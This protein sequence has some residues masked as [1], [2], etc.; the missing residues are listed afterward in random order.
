MRRRSLLVIGFFV[1]TL[2][3]SIAFS[4]SSSEPEQPE[5]SASLKT[6]QLELYDKS[7]NLRGIFSTAE[8][9]DVILGLLPEGKAQ[10]KSISLQMVAGRNGDPIITLRDGS[11]KTKAEL[12]VSGKGDT[13]FG[14]FDSSGSNRVGL[15]LDS[16]GEAAIHI[17]REMGKPRLRLATKADSTAIL[18]Y[19]KDSSPRIVL[20]AADDGNAELSLLSKAGATDT[21]GAPLKLMM[22]QTG[23][24]GFMLV[25]SSGSASLNLVA[26]RNSVPVLAFQSKETGIKTWP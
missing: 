12:S 7:G 23:Q 26:P 9:G 20:A 6:R 2:V 15:I 25:N 22:D 4:V 17:N 16:A 10:G 1:F 19:N 13:T 11:G 21:A 14:F 18:L 3:L 5:I 24:G 8:N